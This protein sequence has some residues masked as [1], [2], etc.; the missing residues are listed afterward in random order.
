MGLGMGQTETEARIGRQK[1]ASEGLPPLDTRGATLVLASYWNVWPENLWS[2]PLGCVCITNQC[3]TDISIRW[4]VT[5]AAGPMGSIGKGCIVL[6]AP[7]QY[8]LEHTHTDMD[9][10]LIPVVFG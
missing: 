2:L 8:R 7:N 9:L 1:R 6:V 10:S 5:T 4:N 3:K